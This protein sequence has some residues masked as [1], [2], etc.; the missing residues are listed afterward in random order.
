VPPG[1]AATTLGYRQH[2]ADNRL[3]DQVERLLAE[4]HDLES[5]QRVSVAIRELVEH[6]RV[7]AALE[8]A[9]LAA[10]ERLIAGASSAPRPMAVRSSATAEDLAQ[11]SF[12]GQQE[13]YLGIL[14]GQEV[15][16]HLVRCWG[17]LFTPQAIAY[18]A[19]RGLYTPGLAMGVVVQRMVTAEA[20]GVMLT[21]DPV[22][23]DRSQ[24]AIEASYGLG[25]AVV[26]GEVTPD[27]FGVDKALLE[28][29]CRAL[30]LK[31]VAYR[32]DPGLQGTRL[33]QVPSQLQ[34]QA[35]LSDAEVLRLA[36][37]GK[38]VEQ[39]MGGRAQDIEWAIGPGESRPREVFL[40]Q[41]RQ[42]TVWSQKHGAPL[43]APDSRASFLPPS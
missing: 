43:A 30:G 14:G 24:I 3:V 16:R 42:E 17:S 10:H 26:N 5:Q 2:L 6:S 34:G 40:L 11:A 15:M 13:T 9:V 18:R 35:C 7:S 29:R 22:T 36:A 20:A 12:A 21:I 28:I 41:T 37:A 25:A 8:D 33:E 38:R 31:D 1:F 23:G 27:R 19:Q 4:A 32:F 39:A